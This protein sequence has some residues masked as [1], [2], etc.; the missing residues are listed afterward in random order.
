[1]EEYSLPIEDVNLQ[2]AYGRRSAANKTVILAGEVA[3][4][5]TTVILVRRPVG[6]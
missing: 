5:R 4:G 1:V 6:N 3:P 2:Q